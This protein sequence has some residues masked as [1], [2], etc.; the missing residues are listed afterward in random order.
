MSDNPLD[1][2]HS[3]D[4]LS[5]RAVV[6]EDGEDPGPALAEAGITDPI[7]LPMMSGEQPLD[8]GFGDGITPG[9]TAVLEIEWHDTPPSAPEFQANPA[10][11]GSDGAG[12]S[13]WA[14]TNL[15]PAFGSKPLAPVRRMAG[16]R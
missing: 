3:F 7:A 1:R 5:I 12:P 15:P 2:I 9:V 14:T 10:R 6:V 13:G 11:P 8:R 4:R 16:T